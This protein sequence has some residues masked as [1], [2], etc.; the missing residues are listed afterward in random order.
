VQREVTAPNTLRYLTNYA[1]RLWPA[2]QEILWTQGWDGQLAYTPDHYPH[3][4]EPDETVLVCLGYNGRGVAMSS[5]MGP[6]LARR[7][8]GGNAAEIDM[9]ITTLREMPSHALWRSGVAARIAYGRI[10][11]MLGP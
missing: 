4:H 5:A 2:P 6:R 3:I 9:P 8:M 10:R 11:D 7:I 1:V